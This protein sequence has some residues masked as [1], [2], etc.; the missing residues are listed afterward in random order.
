MTDAHGP[1]SD[2]DV[3][4]YATPDTGE[5]PDEDVEAMNQ[6]LPMILSF[7]VVPL[8]I[9]II[10]TGVLLAFGLAAY[11]NAEPEQ[12]VQM[13]QSGS[14]NR[15]WQAA[16][17]LAKMIRQDPEGL[18]EQGLG[19][20]LTDVFEQTP[21]DT[22]E[23]RAVRQYVAS[24]LGSLGDPV[25]VP[26]LRAAVHDPDA[27][28]AIYVMTALGQLGAVEAAPDLVAVL[29]DDD[30]GLVKAACYGLGGMP[31]VAAAD[32]LASVLTHGV[33]DVR[34]NAALSLAKLGDTRGGPVLREMMDRQVVANVPDIQPEQVEAVM[35]SGIRG[36][37][38]LELEGLEPVLQRLAEQDPNLKVRDAAFQALEVLRAR[39]E[40]L[41][42]GP[43]ARA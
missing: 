26:A 22:E 4:R 23:N 3:A 12:F 42:S 11:E 34:W 33:A 28:T 16:F 40:A 8:L 14:A 5:M 36:A 32:G 6:T 20:V 38:A 41:A 35:T 15:R 1:Q 29:A 39:P 27:K 24:C 13:L 7:L 30:P 17:E 25:A 19:S 31:S 43:A 21:G 37:T 9:V 10:A 2:D 18:R